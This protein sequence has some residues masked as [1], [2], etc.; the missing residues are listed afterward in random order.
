MHLRATL[1][2]LFTSLTLRVLSWI[3][4][5]WNRQIGALVGRV[6]WAIGSS[7]RRIT[8]TNIQLCYPELSESEQLSLGKDSLIETGRALTE[9]AWVWLRSPK[10][11]RSRTTIVAGE[12]LFREA[13][14]NPQGVIIATP[15]LGNWEACNIIVAA[16][17]PMTYLYR[18]PRADWLEPLII[19]WRANFDAHPAR[20][21]A[22][23]IRTVLQQ[24]R[25]GQVVG[26]LPDQ[27]PDLASGIFAPLFGEPANTM[28]LLQKL[29]RRG[30]AQVLF[31]VCE[32]RAAGAGW[33]LSFLEPEED[34]LHEDPQIAAAAMNRSIERCIALNPAQYLWSYKRFS[35]LPDGGRRRYK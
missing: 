20:L 34:L 29:G 12:S 4:L 3:P 35:L 9:S 22:G 6:A 2:R 15:H 17:A 26:V 18:A 30:R 31:C 33:A 13:L 5:A 16:E 7:L 21:D 10:T 23:G 28:T 19:R 25:S 1:L 27:E 11:L 8:M 24:L 32:R 14:A